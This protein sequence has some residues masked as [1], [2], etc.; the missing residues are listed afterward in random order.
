M[1]DPET[2]LRLPSDPPSS[3]RSGSSRS[4][5]DVNPSSR[6]KLRS[7]SPAAEQA[8]RVDEWRETPRR[9]SR[10]SPR[11]GT[12]S[13]PTRVDVKA[14][15][16]CW[17]GRNAARGFC[18]CGTSG[19]PA[20]RKTLRSSCGIRPGIELDAPSTSIRPRSGLRTGR[21]FRPRAPISSSSSGR[22]SGVVRGG[23]GFRRLHAYVEMG[24]GSGKTPAAA[25]RRPLWDARGREPAPE[26]RRQRDGPG[27]G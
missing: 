23:M 24:K 1:L 25:G 5:S 18:A 22:S 13:P 19:R 27:P 16:P 6:V 11:P 12:R 14:G 26:V 4:G 9:P 10:G 20:R 2:G 15:R 17:P 21:P 3:P 7:R 8:R